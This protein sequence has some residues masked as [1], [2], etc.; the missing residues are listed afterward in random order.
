MSTGSRKD[1]AVLDV[2]VLGA[3]GH[4]QVVVDILRAMQHDRGTV[5]PVAFVDDNASLI[6]MNVIGLPVTSNLDDLKKRGIAVALGVGNNRDRSRLG[7]SALADG[8]RV[9]AAVHPRA[10]IA[11]DVRLGRGIAVCAGVVV[12][13]GAVVH[14][15]AILNTSCSVDHHC[16]IGTSAHIAPGAHLGGT[17]TVGA[18]ALVGVGCSVRPGCS[19]GEGAI[20]GVGS[21]VVSDLEPN[22]CYSGVPA[23]AHSEGKEGSS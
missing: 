11:A 2:V 8:I 1:N 12:N 9:I 4:G 10:H 6:G 21:A 20:V 22:G 17:V 5:R 19:I 3:G 16:I 14:D 15:W 13:I 7:R 23:R 18:G